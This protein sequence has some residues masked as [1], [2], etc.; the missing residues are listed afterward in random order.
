FV[1][2]PSDDDELVQFIKDLG[3]SGQCDKMSKIF[4][5]QIHQP[6]RTFAASI[7][8]CISGKSTRL[9]KLRALRVQILW[10]IYHKL[11]VDFVALLWEDFMFQADNRDISPSRK[12]HM[13]YPRFTKLIISYFIS[14][15]KTISM[16]NGINLHTIRNDSLLGTLNYVS[17]TEDHQIYRALI[18]VE[19]ID[20]DIQTS[21][22]YQTYLAF[23]TGEAIPKKARKFK[24]PSSPK[25]KTVPISS[26]EP[27]KKHAKKAET[28][29][30]SSRKTIRVIIRDTPDVLAPKQKAPSKETEAKKDT[31]ISHPSG[32]G[33]G[34]DFESGVPDEPKGNKI[35]KDEVTDSGDE[36]ENDDDDDDNND[37]SE[38]VGDDD[39][40]DE[41]TESDKEE[42]LNL[43]RDDKD[44]E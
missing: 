32:S 2:P 8:W 29:K 10:E 38:N 24:R 35:S 39:D 12:E 27:T 17:K 11:D 20:Q 36:E 37:D 23:S 33:D 3:Y 25:Q 34:T 1:E 43:T 26:K 13:P 28:V 22:E 4:T 7:N 31:H 15:D 14:K 9:E 19:I 18:P 5:D 21:D 30:T 41:Q 42:D 16:R 6:W 44:K 40:D